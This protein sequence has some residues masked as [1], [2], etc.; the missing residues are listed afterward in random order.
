[1][2][3]QALSCAVIGSPDAV[4]RGLRDFISQTQVDE[5]IITANIYEH[6]ARLKSFEMI[7]EIRARACQPFLGDQ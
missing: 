2:I 6:A 5:L 3:D 1:M 7:A 4:G